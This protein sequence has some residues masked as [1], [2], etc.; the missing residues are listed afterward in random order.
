MGEYYYTTVSSHKVDHCVRIS[1]MMC[2]CTL[3]CL[4][5]CSSSDVDE[6]TCKLVRASY[7]TAADAQGMECEVTFFIAFV[8][9]QRQVKRRICAVV[10]G[11]VRER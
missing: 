6:Q 3:D 7:Y 4:L 8:L 10:Y 5:W 9:T 2:F 1:A 11:S